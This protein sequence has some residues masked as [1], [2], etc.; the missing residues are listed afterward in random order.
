VKKIYKRK[1]EF[2]IMYSQSQKFGLENFTM[3]F[4]FLYTMI[5]KMQIMY[6]NKVVPKMRDITFDFNSTL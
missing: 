5:S 4:N 1:N 6:L 2:M 3:G